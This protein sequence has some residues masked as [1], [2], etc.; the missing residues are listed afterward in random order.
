MVNC[1]LTVPDSERAM[2]RDDERGGEPAKLGA[3]N[4][5]RTAA[6]RDPDS[7]AA[8]GAVKDDGEHG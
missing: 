5:W 2:T 4:R 3:R 8:A 1:E 6:E 7:T